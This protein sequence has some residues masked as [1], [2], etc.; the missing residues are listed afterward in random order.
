MLAWFLAS[1]LLVLL[2]RLLFSG[3]FLV[4]RAVP[5]DPG[6]AFIPLCT[7]FFG[8]A[9]VWGSAM[10]CL[11]GDL[12]TGTWGP[13]VVF[14]AIGWF[15]AAWLF[16]QLSRP[17]RE[18]PKNTIKFLYIS[19]LASVTAAAWNALGTETNRLFP[20]SYTFVVAL[21]HHLVFLCS[22]GFITHR[23]MAAG[24][25]QRIQPW[26]DIIGFTERVQPPFGIV[27]I[28]MAITSCL[29]C[30][31]AWL[32]SVLIYDYVP[33]RPVPLG[34]HLGGW[35]EALV[36]PCMLGQII[37]IFWPNT[38]LPPKQ[39]GQLGDREYAW[40]ALIKG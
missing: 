29:I 32:V 3:A 37:A 19:F 18:N 1:V 22:F 5:Y 15:L 26:E 2:P 25:V 27:T 20:F 12:L 6:V 14:R 36:I 10:G 30:L 35:L 39:D 17:L 24:M 11:L 13:L 33:I 7:M 21:G 38:Q 4:P 31:A 28:L 16:S 9:G 34:G 23:I 8:P 40:S